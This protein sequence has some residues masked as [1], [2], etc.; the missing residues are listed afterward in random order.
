MKTE[1]MVISPQQAKNWLDTKGP[2]RK[3]SPKHIDYIVN[4][5]KMGRWNL[6][7]QGIA[8]AEDGRL[9]DGQHRLA[10]IEKS[11]IAVKMMVTTGVEVGHFAIV[12]RGMPRNMEAITGIPSFYSQC[13][14]LMLQLFNGNTS[15]PSPDDVWRLHKY[16]H[17]YGEE[18]QN[19]SNSAIRYYSSAPVR[20]AAIV[21]MQ[22]KR[23]NKEYVLT[24]YRNLVLQNLKAVSPAALALIKSYNRDP[25]HNLSGGYNIRMV[26]YARARFVFDMKNAN[27]N[28]LH[29]GEIIKKTYMNEIGDIVI[30]ILAKNENVL[31]AEIL[32]K[33]LKEKDEKIRNIQSKLT[34][35]ISSNIHNEQ[36]ALSMAAKD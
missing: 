36:A 31:Q 10:A 9:L 5:I 28:V 25:R 4:E 24:T 26:T 14:I 11:G 33:Q 2:N 19:A 27:A 30:E 34:N 21:A 29:K 20:T 16:L 35:Q 3:L 22:D 7:H 23:N 12:D 1:I 17:N 6:T 32:K 13:Y 18:L 15:K 8:F